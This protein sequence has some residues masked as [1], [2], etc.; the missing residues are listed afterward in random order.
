[1]CR[2][3]GASTVMRSAPARGGAA[4][5]VNTVGST[6]ATA[7]HDVAMQYVGDATLLLKGPISRRIYA[8]TPGMPS[9]AVDARDAAV[10]STS[11]LFELATE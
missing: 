1:M 5:D 6:S 8:L 2:C 9:L 11:R 4:R 7:T 10:F 3:G